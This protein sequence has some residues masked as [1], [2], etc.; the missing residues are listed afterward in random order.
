[1]SKIEVTRTYENKTANES[2][3]AAQIAFTTTNFEIWKTRPHGLLIL[4][5]R[6]TAQGVLNAT[7][8][9]RPAAGVTVL[10]SI[11]GE[12]ASEDFVRTIAD[13]VLAAFE[14]NLC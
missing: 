9:A 6:E 7:F 1:M 8:S 5:N 10:F 13:E 3:N 4:A 14:D 12:S 2:F 11:V